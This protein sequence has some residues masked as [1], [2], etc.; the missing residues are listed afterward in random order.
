MT[1]LLLAS[2]SETRARLLRNAGVAFDIR[3]AHVD[4]DAVKESLLAAGA[5]PREVAGALA[6][7]KAVRVSGSAPDALVLGADQI[8]TIE[9]ELVSK[10]GNLGEARNLLRRLRGRSHELISALVLAKG[11]GAIWRHVESAHLT[12]RGFSDRFLEDYLDAEGE[13]LLKGVGCY[14]LEGRGLQLFDRIEGD[15]FTILGLPLVPLLG[16]LRLHGMVAA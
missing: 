3:P 1:S 13:G 11:G 5:P 14:R 12:M 7:L 8:L 16:V 9:G 2:A 10:C 6:E 15:Y 4:E